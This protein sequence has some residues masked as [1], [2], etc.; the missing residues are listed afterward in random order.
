MRNPVAIVL[1]NPKPGN[2]SMRVA[3]FGFTFSFISILGIIKQ[4]PN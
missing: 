3:P 1:T 2:P 4:N